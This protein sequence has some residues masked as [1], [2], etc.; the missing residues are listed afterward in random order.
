MCLPVG[1]GHILTHTCL[2]VRVMIMLARFIG[3]ISIGISLQYW[4][5]FDS[6]HG[7]H[8]GVWLLE[9]GAEE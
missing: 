4:C 3:I 1:N 7:P 2:K 8:W 9:E 5:H 6:G